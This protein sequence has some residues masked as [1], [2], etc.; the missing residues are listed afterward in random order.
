V[1]EPRRAL[2]TGIAGQDGSYLAELLVADGYAVTGMVRTAAGRDT[3]NLDAIRDQIEFVDGD[4]LDPASLGSALEAAR[5]HELYHLAAPTFVPA[6]WDDPSETIAAIATGTAA[7][8]ARAHAQDPAMRVW[9]SASSEVFGDAGES[10]QHE[11]SPMRP[12]TPYGVAKLA[13]HGLVGAMRARHGLFACSG[14]TYNHESP[15]RPEHFLP[16]KVTRAAAAISLGLQDELV[17][18]DLDAVRDWSHAADVMDAARLALR[19]GEPGDYVVASGVGRTVG[20]LV[21]VAFAHV[22][23]DPRRHVRVDDAL[24]R[25]PEATPLVG[26]PSRAR[27][28]LGWR[29]RHTFEDLVAEMVDADIEALR[30]PS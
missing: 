15:R 1:A 11:R 28:V 26:D 9:V 21:D 27:A 24:V 6:S 18:G 23:L 20:D 13:A 2:I 5:P 29:P 3:E 19:H 17:V 25:P 8:L 10:P 4:L 30:G 16:R 14:I 12:T 7:L 22:G